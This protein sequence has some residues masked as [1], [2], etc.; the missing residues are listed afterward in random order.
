[1]RN[2]SCPWGARSPVG[3][4][5]EAEININYSGVMNAVIKFRAGCSAAHR[6]VRQQ[7]S[8]LSQLSKGL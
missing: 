8:I 2:D 6:A 1:M 3:G 4:E 5:R 7:S